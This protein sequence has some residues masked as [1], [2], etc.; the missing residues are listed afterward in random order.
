MTELTE[1]VELPAYKWDALLHLLAQQI[2]GLNASL[3]KSDLSPEAYRRLVASLSSLVVLRD[4]IAADLGR[5][6]DPGDTTQLPDGIDAYI[7]Q[8]R[9]FYTA[10]P[11]RMFSIPEMA[12]HLSLRVS[13]TK[14]VLELLHASGWLTVEYEQLPPGSKDAPRVYYYRQEFIARTQQRAAQPVAARA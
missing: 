7:E 6:I 13:R 14:L 1:S 4:G 10:H 3:A 9:V 11:N 2:S 8:A 5:T 12:L